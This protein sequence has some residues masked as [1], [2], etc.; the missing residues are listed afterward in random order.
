MK[1]QSR[2]KPTAVKMFGQSGVKPILGPRPR[3]MMS[4][5]GHAFCSIWT[6]RIALQQHV[7][8]DELPELL[9]RQWLGQ[10]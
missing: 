4:E 7:V 6:L 1:K 8:K 2:E 3:R 5:S 10:R 9:A